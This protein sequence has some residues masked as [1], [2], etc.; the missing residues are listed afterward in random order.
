MPSRVIF[1]ILNLSPTAVLRSVHYPLFPF[2][3][4]I[5]LSS[6]SYIF[7]LKSHLGAQFWKQLKLIADTPPIK[8]FFYQ[9]SPLGELV[10]S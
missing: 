8:V 7:L 9:K 3:P 5:R 10:I 1:S 2:N 6:F 4:G